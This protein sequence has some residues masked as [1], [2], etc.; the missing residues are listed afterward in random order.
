MLSSERARLRAVGSTFSRQISQPSTA[1]IKFEEA[2]ARIEDVD[3]A[4]AVSKSVRDQILSDMTVAGQRI[5]GQGRGRAL[6]LL[7]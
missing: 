4:K 6:D 5:S 7:S 1:R 3:I 2:R